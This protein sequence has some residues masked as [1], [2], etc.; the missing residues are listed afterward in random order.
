[1][2]VRLQGALPALHAQVYDAA[3]TRR[4]A[5][6]GSRFYTQGKGLGEDPVAHNPVGER[7]KG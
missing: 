7:H 1:M 6:S 3:V 5:W 2:L 4:G